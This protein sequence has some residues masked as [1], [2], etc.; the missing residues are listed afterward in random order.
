MIG[1]FKQGELNKIDVNGNGQTIYF[2]RDK[3]ELIGVNKG[4]SSNISIYMADGELDRIN[5]ITTPSSVLYP[6]GY[7]A[8]EELYL[9]GFLW[10]AKHRPGNVKDIYKWED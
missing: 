7:L 8:K 6:P 4:E 5:M 10:L 9:S 2:A 3:S 1:F